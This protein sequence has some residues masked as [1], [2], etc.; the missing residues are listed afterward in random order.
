MI[1]LSDRST[2]PA[3]DV[4]RLAANFIQRSAT[5]VILT[6][7]AP[8]ADAIGGVLGLT[9]A[10]RALGKAVTPA[11]SDEVPARFKIMPGYAD[12]VRA[13]STP[14]DL[15]IAL[16]CADRERM[17]RLP[18]GSE[19]QSV[20][21]LNIDHHVT[22][23]RFG[24]VNWIDPAATATSEIV[25]RL[26]DDLRIPLTPDIAANLLH[27]IVGDTLGF[28][29]PHTTPHALESARRLMLAGANLSEIMEH[30]FNRRTFALL[31]LW[32][33]AL[34]TL[35]LEPAS[36]AGYAR[37]CWASLS[38]EA[39]RACGEADWGNNGLSSFLISADEADVAAMLLE[40]DD[41]RID[42]SLRAK[43][44][45]DVSGAAQALGGGG[46]PLASGAAIDGPLAAA[47]ERVLSA[48]K[49]LRRLDRQSIE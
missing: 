2:A 36:G 20:P 34:G 31:C 1:S 25:L 27:G 4:A 9:L 7:T 3:I 13:V 38:R 18:A 24:R 22:N 17:G 16:D 32:S 11:C 42:V 45:F 49:S 6:H 15:L 39:R 12:I 41:G 43:P 28:R 26:I 30:Q 33:K 21:I 10:L 48:L 19:W 8:D 47:T 23:T 14:P 46:H 29:T 37:V 40:K 44:G 35:T 5:V